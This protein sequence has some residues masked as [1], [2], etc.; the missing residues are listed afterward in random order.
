M[1]R[2]TLFWPVLLFSVVAVAVAVLLPSGPAPEPPHDLPWQIEA[3][4][5]GDSRVFGIELGRTPLGELETHLKEPAEIGLFVS[6]AGK[7][8][9]EAYFNSVVLSGLKARIV[10]TLDFDRQALQRL[11]DHGVRIETLAVGRRKVTLSDDDLPLVYRTSVVALTYLPRV[12]LDPEVLRRRFGEP[13]ERI[14]EPGGKIEHWL[15]PA[16]GLDVVVNQEGKDLLQY[17][18]PRRFEQLRAPLRRL[19]AGGQQGPAPAD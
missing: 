18:P 2:K 14:A 6:G 16:K 1:M 10:A 17:V 5:N 7:R 12:D 13:A 4:P 3:L 11:F 9:V 15:Y 8:T 19:S